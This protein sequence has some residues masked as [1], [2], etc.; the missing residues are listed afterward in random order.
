MRP[1]SGQSR[2]Q[3]LVLRQLY[4]GAGIARLRTSSK[5]VQDQVGSVQHPFLQELLDVPKLRWA[6]F[7]VED[8]EIHL[9]L[10]HVLLNLTEFSGANKSLGIGNI[11]LLREALQS[12]SARCQGQKFEFIQVLLD[13][14]LILFKVDD[15][16]EYGRTRSL[17]LPS[18]FDHC[19]KLH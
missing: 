5:D 19:I 6:Q 15:S 11:N 10:Q 2:Q 14:N 12:L 4:L 7:V 17:G 1:H 13:L 9:M 16:N 8:G 3:V 18:G